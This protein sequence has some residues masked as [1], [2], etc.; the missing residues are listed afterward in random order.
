[1]FAF[2]PVV[3]AAEDDEFAVPVLQVTGLAVLSIAT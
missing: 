1:M 2:V 3:L